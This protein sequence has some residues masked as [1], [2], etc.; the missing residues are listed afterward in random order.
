MNN[1]NLDISVFDY[2][3]II[4]GKTAALFEAS[5]FAGALLGHSTDTEIKR[6]RRIGN[7]AGIIF[8]LQD[9]CLDFEKTVESAKKPVQSDYEQGVITLPLIHTLAKLPDFKRKAQ[10]NKVSRDDINQAVEE[11]EGLEFTRQI[12]KRY[13]KKAEL[14][15]SRLDISEEKRLKLTCILKMATGIK[16]VVS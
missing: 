7:Y 1:W 2:F 13:F 10:K 12:M 14:E 4:S 16:T 8:Q 9:D 6:Y 3:K 11:A 5:F 15:I